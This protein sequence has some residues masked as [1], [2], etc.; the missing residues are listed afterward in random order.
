MNTIVGVFERFA[1]DYDRWFDEHSEIYSNQI[2]LL[3]RNIPAGP[4]QMLEIGVGSG[5]FVGPIAP[6][7]SPIPDIRDGL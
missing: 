4:G 3:R 1:D 5:R 6:V 2:D 7:N